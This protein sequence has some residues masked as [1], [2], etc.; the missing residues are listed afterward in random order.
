MK[1]QK[2]YIVA[3][4]IGLVTI[5]G[6]SLYLQYQR[7]MNYTIGSETSED[8]QTLTYGIRYRFVLKL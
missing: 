5:T 3:G 6:A 2:K 4:L 8:K 1:I 7:L